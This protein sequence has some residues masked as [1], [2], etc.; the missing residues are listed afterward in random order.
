MDHTNTMA[1]I[2]YTLYIQHALY[3][4][5]IGRKGDPPKLFMDDLAQEINRWQHSGEKIILFGDFN[6]GD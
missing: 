6:T 5:C 1:Q 4:N 2:R 3:Y